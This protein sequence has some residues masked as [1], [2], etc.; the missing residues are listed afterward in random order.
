MG[1]DAREEGHYTRYF[2]PPTPP[3]TARWWSGGC[4]GSFCGSVI[5]HCSPNNRSR[6]TRGGNGIYL[7]E[8]HTA[9]QPAVPLLLL[10]L[11]FTFTIRLASPNFSPRPSCPSKWDQ[12]IE[13]GAGNNSASRRYCIALDMTS[14]WM[15]WE[16]V[17][18]GMGERIEN[19]G[20]GQL[21]GS[22][23]R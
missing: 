1:R 6:S 10:L 4:T 8:F 22:C 2:H 18:M 3:S 11:T 7:L 23:E 17:G 14:G 5:S 12:M 15:G 9:S 13:G 16:E 19:M 20:A 21:G